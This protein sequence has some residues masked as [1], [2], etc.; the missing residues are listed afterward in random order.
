[1][2]VNLQIGGVPEHFNYPWY[3]ALKNKKFQSQDLKVRWTDFPGGTGDMCKALRNGSID[4]AIVLTEGIIKDIIDGNP[5]RILQTYVQSP[6]IWGIH[7]RSDSNFNHLADLDNGRIAISRFGSGS[8]LMAII[9]AYNQGWSLDSLDFVEV[10]DLEGGIRA[11]EQKKADYF[12]W[13]RFT[14]KPYVDQGVF[15]RIGICPTPWPCFVIA[16]RESVISN[17]AESIKKL[18][19]IINQINSN[20]KSIPNIDRILSN[21]YEQKLSDVQQWLSLTQWNSKDAI[22]EEFIH[23]V[24]NK[25]LQFNVIQKTIKTNKLIKNMYI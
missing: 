9:N 11:I 22:T 16:A 7:V 6:L 4:I 13:E 3:L 5:S 23:E 24:Q 14:T 8:H 21:R 10:G 20:F 18:L 25:L 1:M 12:L 19:G 17:Q 15:R 2:S